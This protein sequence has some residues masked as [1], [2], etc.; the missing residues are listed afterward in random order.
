L[1]PSILQ[2][3]NEEGYT[4]PTPIQIQAIPPVNSGKDLLGIAQTGTGKTAA[5]A[6]PIL[7][8]LATDPHSRKPKTTRVLVLVPTRE[9]AIQVRE[10]FDHY[11]IHLHL[12]TACIYGGVADGPQKQVML[13]GVDI[14]VATPGRLLDLLGQRSL[15]LNTLGIFVLDEADRML[16][17]GFINDIRKIVALL[18]KVR[19]NLFFSATMPEDIAGLASKILHNPVRVEVTP[20]STPIEIIDQIVYAVEKRDKQ[21]LLMT[22]LAN[23][24]ITR[25]LVF[26]RTKHG[27]NRVCEGLQKK[28]ISVAA[29]HGNK[30]QNRRQEALAGF[31]RGSIKILVATDIAARGIDVD[32]ISHV[33]NFDLPEVPETYVHRIGRTARAGASGAAISFCSMEERG[34]L[35]AIDRLIVKNIPRADASA[36]MKQQVIRPDSILSPVGRYDK[37]LG[38][39]LPGAGDRAHSKPE[40]STQSQPGFRSSPNYRGNNGSRLKTNQFRDHTGQSGKSPH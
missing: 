3:V 20:A 1:H 4:I 5:F 39:Y 23:K 14:L 32:K 24:S 9:L 37:D 22:L 7:N 25:A 13:S 11:G 36:I 2:A 28:G 16:D 33:F 10:S 35:A 19:Q 18:P 30:S 8:R 15:S 34:Y 31:Q 27:A 17:M 12:R 38:V 40:R 29:I 26:T 21:Q 6:L